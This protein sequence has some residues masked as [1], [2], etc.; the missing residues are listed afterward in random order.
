MNFGKVVGTVV[1][2]KAHPSFTG[3]T[4]KLLDP[5]DESG[6]KTGDTLTAADTAGTREGDLVCWV[7]SAEA[8]FALENQFNPASAAITAIIDRLPSGESV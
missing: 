8:A 6:K 7:T 2:N 3:I 5:T 1:L 4:L